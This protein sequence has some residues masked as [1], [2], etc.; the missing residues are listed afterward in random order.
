MTT[1]RIK[2]IVEASSKVILANHIEPVDDICKEREQSSVEVNSLS[3]YL[4]GG[5]ELL[6]RQYVPPYDIRSSVP[7]VR[8]ISLTALGKPRAREVHFFHP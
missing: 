7:Q 3:R 2:D 4:Y 1:Q 6:D 5:Q 8:S